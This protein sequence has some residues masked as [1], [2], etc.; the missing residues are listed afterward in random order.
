MW[1]WHLLRPVV[2]V[3]A[4]L[5]VAVAVDRGLAWIDDR[6]EGDPGRPTVFTLLRGCRRPFLV[7]LVSSVLAAGLGWARLPSDWERGVRHVLV[8]VLLAS[9]AWLASRLVTLFF[10]LS[11]NRY[12]AEPRDPARVRRVRTQTVMLRRIANAAIC[13]V[14]L[15]AALLTFREVRLVGTSL[16]ASAGIIAA[17]AG[18]AAQSTLGNLFAGIQVAFADMARIGDNVVIGGEWGT[19]EEITLTYVVV[20]TWDQRRLVMPVSYLTSQPFENWSRN[21]TRITGAVLLYLDHRTPVDAIRTEFDRLL[22]ATPLWDGLG[23]ALQVVDTTQSG[24]VV[25]A[26]MTAA[27]AGTVF[28]L[29]CFVREGLIAFLAREHPAALPRVATGP[30]VDEGG[31]TSGRYSSPGDPRDAAEPGPP[32]DG[33][34]GHGTDPHGADSGGLSSPPVRT[35]AGAADLPPVDFPPPDPDHDPARDPLRPAARAAAGVPPPGQE[36]DDA[37][38][39]RQPVDGRISLVKRPFAR[40]LGGR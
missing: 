27:D 4:A 18:V 28:D 19:V 13:V 14:A 31:L 33:S 9:A 40:L 32:A 24:I 23:K 35:P 6:T 15:G 16:L 39:G 12:A 11:V 8:L 37:L 36:P 20:A 10:E 2:V 25:R 3:A 21:D 30:A 1:V 22:A 26:L 34:D 38:T 17:I 29:R 7:C 5:A